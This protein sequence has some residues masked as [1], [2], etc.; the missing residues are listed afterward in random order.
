MEYLTYWSYTP[1]VLLVLFALFI[2]PCTAE[3]STSFLRLNPVMHTEMIN[4]IDLS[5]DEEILATASD[6]KTV[7]LWDLLGGGRLYRVLR[8]PI[9]IGNEGKLFAVAMSPNGY[10]VATGGWTKGSYRGFGNHNIYLFNASNG[11]IVNRLIGL[12]NTV[13]HLDYSP[14]SKY[15]AGVLSGSN[16]IRVWQLPNLTEVLRDMDYAGDSYWVEFS[17]DGKQLV[18]SSYDGYIRL[19]GHDS[20]KENLQLLHK[21]TEIFKGKLPF[22]VR[23][24]PDGEKIAVGFI[25]SAYVAIVATKDL[26]LLYWTTPDQG[27]IGDLFVTAWS[28]DGEF[29]YGGGG[30]KKDSMLNILQWSNVGEDTIPTAWPT[31]WNTIMSL[32]TL[33]NQRVLYVDS[34]P[35]WGILDADGKEIL[36][37]HRETV[38]FNKIFPD[39][40]LVSEDAQIVQFELDTSLDQKT[41]NQKTPMRF[42]LPERRLFE[43]DHELEALDTPIPTSVDSTPEHLEIS[44]TQRYPI[45]NREVSEAPDTTTLPVVTN[46]APEHLEISEIQRYLIE[47]GL[48]SG[49]VDNLMGPLTRTAIKKFQQAM[50]LPPSGKLDQPTMTALLVKKGLVNKQTKVLPPTLTAPDL[51]IKSWKNSAYPQLNGKPL[52]LQTND[53]AISYA[54]SPLGNSL[55]LGTRFYLYHYDKEGQMLWQIKSPGIVW[56]VNVAANGKLLVAAFSDS[57]LRWFKLEDGSELL[58]LYPHIDQRRWVAWT[59]AGIY[60]ASVGADTLLGWHVN[61]R[62]EQA[63][64]FFPVR[65]LRELYYQP[66]T[67]IQVLTENSVLQTAAKDAG[68]AATL[69]EDKAVFPLK[70]EAIPIEDKAIPISDTPKVFPPR[71]LL[72]MPK[73]GDNFSNPEIELKY[74]LRFHGEPSPADLYLM[75]Y[76]R[77]W[78]TIKATEQADSARG[79]IT[80]TLPQQDVEIALIAKNVHGVSPPEV[81][82]LYW[83]GKKPSRPVQPV[84]YVLSIGISDYTDE[85]LGDLPFAREDAAMF[86]AMWI[87][88]TKYY[89]EIKVKNLAD[90]SYTEIMDSLAWL[91]QKVKPQ[92]V[93]MVFFAG[94]SL[95]HQDT[96]KNSYF[97]LPANATPTSNT[98]STTM[99]IEAFSGIPS[100]VLLFMDTA[101]FNSLGVKSEELSPADIDGFANELSSP[102]NGIIVFS[103]VVGTQSS[104]TEEGSHHG[105]FTTV[106]L[107]ALSGKADHDGD[108]QLRLLEMGNY[109]SDR[110][111]ELTK[112]KQTPVLAIPETMTDF[113]TVGTVIKP[114]PLKATS[115]IEDKTDGSAKSESALP[116]SE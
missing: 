96:R 92:D 17:P 90:S 13:L 106:L 14:D 44:E 29:L 16:G 38:Y 57:T 79:R 36:G 33:A 68:I 88:Q 41:L 71:V 15:L 62:P 39:G 65:C 43:V 10:Q 52:S 45:K 82:L 109:V 2:S 24:S 103:S 78:R 26:S 54:F 34:T 1:P 84:L 100:K 104:Q 19:Y 48:F 115:M 23:F 12:E 51:E 4:R 69:S 111:S 64:D 93:V 110:V 55:V 98:I 89:R 32:R 61:N 56:A 47:K 86:A 22:A 81:A 20:Q 21:E 116:A 31:A 5:A 37:H 66:Q 46:S 112:G 11:E 27:G 95:Q 74:Q 80:V 53:T 94:H 102:E 87:Q 97:F 73:D 91:H 30:Y 18:S 9:G 113:F 76:G 107:E 105:I 83:K 42:S 101:Y 70:N 77:P 114:P 99:L 6:D 63:A 59:P 40:L 108:G 49:P 50:N 8:P 7:R 58:A 60:A 85:T 72:Q 35:N 28:R 25:N 67:L 75:V 3:E